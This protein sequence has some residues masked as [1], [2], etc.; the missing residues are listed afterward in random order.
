MT[1]ELVDIALYSDGAI[2]YSELLAMTPMEV[3]TAVTRLNKFMKSKA[4]AITG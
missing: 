1:G 3:E 4:D 2:T